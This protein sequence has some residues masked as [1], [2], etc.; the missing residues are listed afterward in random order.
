M[1]KIFYPGSIVVVGVS[2]KA[3]NLSKNIAENIIRYQYQGDL[4]FLGRNKG[5]LQGR[6]IFSSVSELPHNIDLAVI[7]TPAQTV[8]SFLD[9]L[10]EIGVRNALIETAGFSEFSED[11]AL[12]EQEIAQIAKKWGMK[13]VGPNC[14]GIISMESGINTLFVRVEKDEM[15][16]GSAT[17]ISQSGGVVLT[18]TNFMTAGGLGVNKTVSVGNKLILKEADYLRYF[19]NDE[20]TK[21]ILLYLESIVEGREIV[22]LTEH[23][24]KP[25]IVY[26]SNTSQASA[27]IA[28]SHTAA[29]SNDD[30]LVSAAFKQYGVSRVF[31]FREMINAGKGFK[32]PPIR[33][34]KLAIFSRSGGHAIIS[35]DVAHDFGFTLPA[36]PDELFEIAKPYFRVNVIDKQNP[37]DMG[38]VFDFKSYLTI[39]EEAIKL[40]QPDAVLLIFNYLRESR[41]LAKENAL[42]FKEMS[43]KY[44]TPIALVYLT[45]LDE[46]RS[47]ERDLGYPV[48]TEVYDAI[49]SLAFT[50]DYYMQKTKRAA[51][52]KSST[53]FL[54]PVDSKRKVNAIFQQVERKELQIDQALQLCEAY[55]LPTAPWGIALS[56]QEAVQI[57]VRIGY[58]VVLKVAGSGSIHKTDVGGVALNLS[59]AQEISDAIRKIQA[60]LLKHGLAQE[61]R[62]LVQKMVK[63]GREIIMGGKQD[64]AF[65]PVVLCGL[66]GIYAEVFQDVSLRLAPIVPEEAL[67]ML[68]ELRG[69]KYLT[70]VRGEKG[71]NL[72]SIAKMLS[73]VSRMMA[74][75]PQISEF[76]LNPVLAFEDSVMIV[77]A[78]MLLL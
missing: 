17:F 72:A 28:K 2:E 44:Q 75:N 22:E 15:T 67:E 43:E 26:K 34:N 9:Q 6:P 52:K 45:E 60:S 55:D 46:V 66:G 24:N 65:G 62:F 53:Q 48:F 35:T 77:D 51:Y 40:T 64:D 56:V 25:V 37:L 30:K 57:A 27:E 18:G 41:P 3:D 33:G 11:G 38:T 54:L 5:E 69:A 32:M 36:F 70:G 42:K 7:L 12:L 68:S 23:G 47:L 21:I 78:R 31:S 63:G 10:G 19:L 1:D 73:G 39:I 16:P 4:Y 71:V 59:S 49:Q 20:T 14:V 76:D 29:L 74:D 61:T 8:P 50:R 13:V 58:P